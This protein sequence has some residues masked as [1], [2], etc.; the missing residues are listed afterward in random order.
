MMSMI[1]QGPKQ[2]GNGIDTY[3]QLLVDELETLWTDG[4]KCWDAFKKEIFDL[5]VMLVQTIHDLLA[6][7]NTSG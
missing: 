3:L 6:F 1:I 2:L 4:V 7:G 5:K